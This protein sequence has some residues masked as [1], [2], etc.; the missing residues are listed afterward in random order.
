VDAAA[1]DSDARANAWSR[2]VAAE[3]AGDLQR[4]ESIMTEAWGS[5]PDNYWVRLRLAYLAL[6]RGR[7]SEARA[8]YQDL[9]QWP[10]AQGD[11]DV[12]QGLA[13]ALAASGWSSLAQGEAMQARAAFREALQ[14]DPDNATARR[15][16][17][18][19]PAVPRLLPEVWSGVTG[20]S[21]ARTRY[22]GWVV[23]GNL[24]VRLTEHLTLRASGRHMAMSNRST[25][26]PWSTG[27]KTAGWNLDE[28]FVGLGYE[29]PAL[30]WDVVGALSKSSGAPLISGGGA[31]L[32]WGASKGLIAEGALLRDRQFTNAQL[33]PLAF[34][35]LGTHVGLQAGAR[36]TLDDRG[37]STSAN[38]GASLVFGSLGLFLQGHCGDER[39]GFDFTGPSLMSFEAVPS[40]G[41]AATV[42]WQ[43]SRTVRLAAQ[44]EGERLHQEG[45]LGS[46]WS[47]SLGIQVGMGDR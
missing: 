9:R 32:R 20:Q 30:A 2:S 21:L 10:E 29:S 13:S 7:S 18:Q 17:V 19:V 22:V 24:P 4:A 33:R 23:Y 11:A 8:R 46:F 37:N 39:W 3:K 14:V 16:L 6:V 45:A 44:G 38:A 40:W 27:Q 35:W 28:G 26:S 5:Q 42:T 43:L 15:G 36:F 25:K 41:G 31:R 47:A 34:L 12:Q 1:D